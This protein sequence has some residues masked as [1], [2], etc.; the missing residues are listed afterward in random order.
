[1]YRSHRRMLL[2]AEMTK[3]ENCERVAA[4]AVLERYVAHG[5]V[6]PATDLDFPRLVA[7]YL[8][9]RVARDAAREK[10]SRYLVGKE[11]NHD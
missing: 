8:A 7:A 10:Y 2:R 5:G 6:P 3:T 11:R 9:A 4:E 1:M